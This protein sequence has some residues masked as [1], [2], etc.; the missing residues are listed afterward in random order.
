MKK[1][2]LQPKMTIENIGVLKIVASSIPEVE[3]DDNTTDDPSNFDTKSYRD[4]DIWGEDDIDSD[5]E[6]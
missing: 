2:Y 5:D 6:W 3:F 4:W 1:T